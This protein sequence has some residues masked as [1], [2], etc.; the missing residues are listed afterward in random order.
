MR[1]QAFRAKQAAFG[2]HRAHD[3]IGDPAFVEPGGALQ[4]D[5]AQRLGQQRQFHL[6]AGLRRLA[7]RQILFRRRRIAGEAGR[8]LGP[9]AAVG[10]RGR[11]TT[12][13]LADVVGHRPVLAEVLERIREQLDV[14]RLGLER[15]GEALRRVRHMC[16]LSLG[17]EGRVHLA[18]LARRGLD[19]RDQIV[20]RRPDLDV[21]RFGERRLD[22]EAA[23][24]LL[25][26]LLLDRV[27][28]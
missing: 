20:T 10:R 12:G 6:V 28:Q 14:L 4:D 9:V 18:G 24:D 1:R 2:L 7:A 19:P 22:A 21:A 27:G 15:I 25:V 5:L 13:G 3:V 11:H 23:Q 26:V 16:A 17:H 8:V